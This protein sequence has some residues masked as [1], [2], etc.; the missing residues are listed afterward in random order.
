[1]QR[2]KAR[3][4]FKSILARIIFLHVIAVAIICALMPLLLYWLLVRETDSLQQV[5]MLEHADMLAAHL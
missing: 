5:A 2:L 1:L 4:R 3:I